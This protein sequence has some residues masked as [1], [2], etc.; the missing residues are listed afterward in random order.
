MMN[1]PPQCGGFFDVVWKIPYRKKKEY[2]KL[3]H[4]RATYI[5]KVEK[6]RRGN[7]S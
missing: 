4:G 1:E 5:I 7:V 2:R 3:T 6:V